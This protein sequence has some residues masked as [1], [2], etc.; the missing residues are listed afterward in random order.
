MLTDT[1]RAESG[2]RACAVAVLFALKKSAVETSE[3]GFVQRREQFGRRAA[4][5]KAAPGSECER[6][7]RRQSDSELWL[8]HEYHTSTGRLPIEEACGGGFC[9][10]LRESGRQG[11]RASVGWDCPRIAVLARVNARWTSGHTGS[12]LVTKP[13][14]VSFR[15]L[16]GGQGGRRGLMN[17]SY[18]AGGNCSMKLVDGV[19]RILRL[20]GGSRVGG[21]FIRRSKSVVIPSSVDMLC[22]SFVRGLGS[23]ESVTFEAGCRLQRIEE[24]AFLYSVLISIII[25]SSV[26]ILC[27]S[28]FYEC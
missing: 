7:A 6:E 5:R 3:S 27:N 24:S 1:R 26:E 20:G 16:F 14:K 23:I 28:C 21:S 22:R 2:R 12:Q 8:K 18:P 19:K 13:G 25:P 17:T 10:G 9:K 11:V 4:L 15:E